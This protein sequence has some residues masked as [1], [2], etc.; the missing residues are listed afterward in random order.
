MKKQENKVEKDRKATENRLLDTIGQMIAEDGFEKTG[1]NSVAT[2]SGVSKVLIYRYFGS[3]EG[4]MTAYIQRHDFWLN[5][6]YEMPAKEHLSTFLKSMFRLQ[7]E[8]LRKDPILKRLYRWELSSTNE[9]IDELRKQ[10]EEK[11]LW[12]VESVS[13]LSEHPQKEVAAMATILN[14]AV[15]YLVML[16]DFCPQYNGIA[17]KE[18]A[19][20]EQIAQ[21]IDLLIEQWISTVKNK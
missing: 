6:P 10:R 14:A 21:G 12:I 18:D 15:T 5:L 9:M 17:L 7:I 8:Q 11:G 1:I 16:E 2:K 4:L 3:V 20:W 13:K 19:G